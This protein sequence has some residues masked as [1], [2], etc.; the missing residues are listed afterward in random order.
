MSGIPAS[1]GADY[2]QYIND[3]DYYQHTP[4]YSVG[5]EGML[6]FCK[7][8]ATARRE[9]LAQHIPQRRLLAGR[10]DQPEAAAVAF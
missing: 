8:F 6:R 9:E 2:R 10:L 7:S 1:P 3:T 4:F 5:G